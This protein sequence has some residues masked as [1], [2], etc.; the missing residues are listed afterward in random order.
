MRILSWNIQWGRGCDGVVDLAR[1]ARNIYTIGDFDAICLQEVAIANPGLAGSQGEDG[2]VALRDLFPDYQ[3]FFSAGSDLPGPRGGR[4][5]FGNVV[6]TRIPALQVWR[7]LLPHP[8]DAAVPSM[9]RTCLEVIVSAPSGPLRILTTHLEYYSALQRQAQVERLRALQCEAAGHAR[10]PRPDKAAGESDPPFRALPRPARA[11][12]CGD[13]NFRPDGPDY[14]AL[15]GEIGTDIACWC[16]A[17]RVAGQPGA[18]GA[19]HPPTSGVH[20]PTSAGPYCCD[21]MFVTRD[22]AP[23]VRTI[24]VESGTTASDHQPIWMEIDL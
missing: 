5:L 1:I 20:Q 13:F 11:I 2:V 6:L 18:R 24:R 21:F 4:A 15:T 16:D 7:H 19:P 14:I 22:I 9:Q 12:L 10:A 3:C 23:A 17:W 8:A